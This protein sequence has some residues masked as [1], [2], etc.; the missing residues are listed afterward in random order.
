ML[1]GSFRLWGVL[2]LVAAAAASCSD[3]QSGE[4]VTQGAVT[5]RPPGATSATPAVPQP[6]GGA[7]GGACSSNVTR[8][9]PTSPLIVNPKVYF[10]FWGSFWSTDPGLTE[11]TGF[12]DT[13]S[14]MAASEAF[15][16]Q[17]AEYG[18]GNG[19]YLGSSVQTPNLG[20]GA[21][22]TEAT[23]QTLLTG[24]I[25]S[26]GVPTNDANTLYVIMM[27][28]GKQSTYDTTNGF[29]GHHGFTNKNNVK[30]WYAVVEHQT[31]A[32]TANNVISHE[33]YEAATDPD[34]G[35]GP[36][37]VSQAGTGWRDAVGASDE[38][39][40]ICNLNSETLRGT[41]IQ[42]VWSQRMCACLGA[43]TGIL[44][45]IALRSDGNIFHSVRL[46]NQFWESYTAL[47]L[48]NP[49]VSRVEMQNVGGSATQV[50]ALSLGTLYHRVRDQNGNWTGWG[51]A[52][53]A[54]GT[55]VSIL[56]TKFG[57][58][59]DSSAQMHLCVVDSN[60][61]FRHA[62]RFADGTWSPLND[63]SGLIG[64]PGGAATTADCA[65]FGGA[66]QM[67]VVNAA[68]A[69]YHAIRNADGSWQGLNL[70]SSNINGRP[71]GAVTVA[72]VGNELHALAITDPTFPAATLYHR[73][74]HADGTWT[75]WGTPPNSGHYQ[76]VSSGEVSG[77]LHVAVSQNGGGA[78]FHRI[79]HADGT[80]TDFSDIKA[81]AGNPGTLDS[82][83]LT[84][85][86]SVSW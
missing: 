37:G 39:G 79:R 77:E 23:V 65:G 47:D 50:M 19:Q 72:N 68:G 25:G 42:Q 33:I 31:T 85:S 69:V 17:L 5:G 43:P 26:G 1:S 44:E 52:S 73:V 34:E 70:L 81:Q 82:V 66:V 48:P 64:T 38:I 7:S 35:S 32:V 20:T 41:V 61:V 55:N 60:N 11:R 6:P 51:N 8:Q 10:L 15:Y 16:K 13:W 28:T 53:A 9:S 3:G 54:M 29:L 45:H 57:M 24:Q 80:W 86:P 18:I 84:G 2:S 76:D 59:A 4:E 63:T 36:G 74:R 83:T 22:V 12:T 71:V 67:L 49:S 56:G 46:P 75:N 21:T 27:P 30:V 40:D 58:A 78:T 14:T 62:V